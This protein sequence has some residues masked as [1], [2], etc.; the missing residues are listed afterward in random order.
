MA[1][2]LPRRREA[3]REHVRGRFGHALAKQPFAALVNI[4]L[5]DESRI[6]KAPLAVKAGGW[7]LFAERGWPDTSDPDYLRMRQLVEASIAPRQQHDI[8]GTCGHDDGCMCDSCWV[9]LKNQ[10]DRESACVED[11]GTSAVGRALSYWSRQL[12]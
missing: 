7:G 1:T 9:R 2:D 5:P 3:L 6:L 12:V 11:P 4:A 10:H 8:A